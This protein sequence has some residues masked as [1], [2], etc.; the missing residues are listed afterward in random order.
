VAILVELAKD[1]PDVVRGSDFLEAAESL[2]R[3]EEGQFDLDPIERD[4][5]VG[6]LLADRLRFR[7]LVGEIQIEQETYAIRYRDYVL[8]IATTIQIEGQRKQLDEILDTL[9][10]GDPAATIGQP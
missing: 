10:V 7:T 6:G 3:Q 5:R 4:Q 1:R 9:T 2:M 8:I